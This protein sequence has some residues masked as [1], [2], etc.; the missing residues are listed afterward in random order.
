M[1]VLIG[2]A[3]RGDALRSPRLGFWRCAAPFLVHFPSEENDYA[4]WTFSEKE[5]EEK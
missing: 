3:L 1:A 2:I 5:K 4:R